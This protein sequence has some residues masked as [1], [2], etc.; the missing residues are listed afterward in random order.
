[1]CEIHYFKCPPCS[2][3]WQEYKKLA[4]C[5][6]FEPEARCP[7]NL[8]LYVGMEK[9]P[10]IRECDECRDLREILESFEEE[11]EGE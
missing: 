7:E 10:E 6:S 5:E 9:K 3:R 2:K 4:S 1:M 11:G 8:V